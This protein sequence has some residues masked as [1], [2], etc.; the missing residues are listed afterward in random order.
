MEGAVVVGK[1]LESDGSLGYDA[2]KDEYCNLIAAG[3]IDPMKVCVYPSICCQDR[4]LF[5]K[6]ERPL[7]AFSVVA[8]HKL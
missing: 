1:L 7:S 4:K 2:S 3:I 8:D 5:R 6:L